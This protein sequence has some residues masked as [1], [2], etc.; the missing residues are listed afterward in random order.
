[1]PETRG[2]LSPRQVAEVFARFEAASPEPKGELDHTTPFELLVAV[3]LSAQATDKGVNQAT[4]RLFPDQTY[5]GVSGGS[6]AE[7]W[8]AGR[9]AADDADVGAGPAVHGRP[10]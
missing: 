7:G 4:A 8:Y 2:L 5:A 6:D 3:V 10:R 1:M 9:R